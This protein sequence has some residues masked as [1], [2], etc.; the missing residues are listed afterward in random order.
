[1]NQNDYKTFTDAWTTANELMPA[2]KVLSTNAMKLCIKALEQYPIEHLLAAIEHHIKTA[3]FAPAPKDIIDLLEMKQKRLSADEAWAMMPKDEFE[4][5]VWT[6]EMAAAYDIAYDLI[7]DG[8]RIAARMAFKGAYERLCAEAD[9]MSKPVCWKVALGYDKALIE[10]VLQKAVELGRISHES[11]QHY[12]PAPMDAGPIA[13]LLTGKVLELPNNAE[14]LRERWSGL[15]QALDDANKRV[16]EERQR[17]I[18]EAAE[19]R[20]EFEERRQA[21]VDLVKRKT[22]EMQKVQ[23]TGAIWGM[24]NE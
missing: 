7:V 20:I 21:A 22:E 18:R 8:D 19:K 3:Q 14:H 12:L 1:M 24:G 9:L 17:A 23:K 13:G 4:T 16:S 10:P 11:V 6:E 2:G 15:K 5:V